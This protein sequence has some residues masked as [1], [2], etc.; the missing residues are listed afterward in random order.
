MRLFDAPKKCHVYNN[1]DRKMVDLNR[2]SPSKSTNF[3]KLKRI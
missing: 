1:L 3:I 2:I